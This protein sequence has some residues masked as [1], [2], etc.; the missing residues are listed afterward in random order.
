MSK[1]C[2]ILSVPEWVIFQEQQSELMALLFARSSEYFPCQ[3]CL[4]SYDQYWQ[5]SEPKFGPIQY[6]AYRSI[7]WA[8][9]GLGM[10]SPAPNRTQL[11]RA[12]MEAKPD[13]GEPFEG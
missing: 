8:G 2:F 12:E 9:I 3:S 11:G 1:E 10:L 13:P 6:P 7:H 5:T 4:M